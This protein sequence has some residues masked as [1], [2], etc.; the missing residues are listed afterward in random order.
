M[1]YLVW[2]FSKHVSPIFRASIEPPRTGCRAWK[3]AFKPIT[4]I[5]QLKELNRKSCR[6]TGLA[7]YFNFP[8]AVPL[9]SFGL[10][11]EIKMLNPPWN[12]F[13]CNALPREGH[14]PEKQI[15]FIV[16]IPDAIFIRAPVKK[17]E[18]KKKNSPLFWNRVNSYIDC[19]H[20]V[21]SFFDTVF[22]FRAAKQK[23]VWFSFSPGNH[24]RSVF[25]QPHV[26]FK[27]T[28]GLFGCS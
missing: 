5:G 4:L 18:Q 27:L 9:L 2:N 20:S 12:E 7:F 21:C 3:N 25:K 17:R 10:S 23:S 1:Q 16:G 26:W 14:R 22:L 28:N 13:S 19:S 6:P 24:L 8:K 11:R 15:F